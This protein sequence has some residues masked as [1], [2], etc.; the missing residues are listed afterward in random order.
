MNYKYMDRGSLGCLFF[1]FL[2]LLSFKGLSNMA[3]KTN[4]I[5]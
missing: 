3:N 1:H 5:I 2:I 4:K